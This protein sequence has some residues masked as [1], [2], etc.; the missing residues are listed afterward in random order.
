MC[1]AYHKSL[2]PFTWLGYLAYCATQIQCLFKKRGI[3]Y[4]VSQ[5]T[6]QYIYFCDGVEES[7]SLLLGLQTFPIVTF[8]VVLSFW[9]RLHLSGCIITDG[10]GVSSTGKTC[11]YKTFVVKFLSF[12]NVRFGEMWTV[13]VCGR[14]WFIDVSLM[15]QHLRE[16]VI[17]TF[18]SS[19]P[20]SSFHL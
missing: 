10:T 15:I 6:S 9:T 4:T 18:D 19:I 8:S 11:C 14:H 2:H 17:F 3:R 5:T 12:S 7:C 1:W 20:T 13:A 16:V